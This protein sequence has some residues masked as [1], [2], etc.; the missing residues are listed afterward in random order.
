MDAK[1]ANVKGLAY[2]SILA[3]ETNVTGRD[4]QRDAK[5]NG[6]FLRET[7]FR[8]HLQ[9]IHFITINMA[10]GDDGSLVSPL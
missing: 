3:K 2:N 4:M 7:R 5:R 8:S 1:G 10:L 6:N 9:P